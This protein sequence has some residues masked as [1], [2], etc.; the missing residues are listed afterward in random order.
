MWQFLTYQALDAPGPGPID[1]V[2]RSKIRLGEDCEWGE[3]YFVWEPGDKWRACDSNGNYPH[4][5]GNI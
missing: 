1:V 2:P 4:E 5:P 3:G